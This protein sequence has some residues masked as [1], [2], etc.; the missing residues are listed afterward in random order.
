[1]ARP[2]LALRVLCSEA[3][4]L[5]M[6]TC[7]QPAAAQVAIEEALSWEAAFPQLLSPICASLHMLCGEDPASL[8]TIC[9]ILNVRKV[10]EVMQNA[11]AQFLWSPFKQVVRYMI[12]EEGYKTAKAHVGF[13]DYC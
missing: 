10:E 8:V 11:L 2:L 9:R 6:L 1:M 3:A 7:S 5:S 13:L 12:V 4:A